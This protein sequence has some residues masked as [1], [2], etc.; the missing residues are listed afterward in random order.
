MA[1]IYLEPGTDATQD[2]TFFA[3]T[4]GT[5]TSATDQYVTGGRSLKISIASSFSAAKTATGMAADTGRRISFNYRFTALPAAGGSFQLLSVPNSTDGEVLAL[6]LLPGGTIRIDNGVG[7]SLANG[8][9]VLSVN[10]W[11]RIS[12]SY[13][14]TN[15]TTFTAKYYLNGVL[16]ATAIDSGT[17]D[18][19]GSS[20]VVFSAYSPS[21]TADFWFDNIYVD[22]GSDYTDPGDI[23]VTAKRP[24]ANGTTND[25]ST[26]IGAGGS[27]YGSGHSPQVNERPL[28]T[29]NGWSIV[30]AGSAVTEEYNIENL[31]TGD[32]DLTSKTLVDYIGWLYTSALAAETG[33]IIVNNANSNIAL[34]TTN[35]LF[36]KVAGSTTYPAGTGTDIGMITDT[37]LTTV[38]LYECGII[39]AYRT[40]GNFFPFF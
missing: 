13:T 39:F 34:T 19:T 3:S 29:T 28:S 1:T 33:Q 24:N 9:T 2:L 8:T 11:Y 38:S 22:D 6:R 25:F 12:F 18:G 16:E 21:V 26:Q 31:S 15:T 40:R 36:I 10:T 7:T 4:V 17:L 32:V 37:T 27:G 30:G 14:V 5:A 20:K 35:T 23:R